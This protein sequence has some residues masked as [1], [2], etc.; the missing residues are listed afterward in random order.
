M[1]DYRS[2]EVF[3]AGGRWVFSC[4]LAPA[5]A[6]GAVIASSK[7]ADVKLSA[8]GWVMQAPPAVVEW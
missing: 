5:A 8:A 3:V 4:G 2:T 1:T 6:S 7:V